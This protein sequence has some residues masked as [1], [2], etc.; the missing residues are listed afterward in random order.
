MKILPALLCAVAVNFSLPA[1]GADAAKA[2]V[3]G[4]AAVSK[5]VTADEAAALLKKRPDALVVDVRTPDEFAE[6]HIAGA[7]N[8]DFLG[9]HFEKGIAALPS[10]KPLIVHCAA[11]NRSAQAVAKIAALQ[12]A[13]EVYHLK[14]GFNGWKSAGKPVEAKTSK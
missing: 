5:D 14:S 1:I 9:D 12:K 3:S 7:K 4:K 2:P 6:G 11:G 10:D 8:V 13:H